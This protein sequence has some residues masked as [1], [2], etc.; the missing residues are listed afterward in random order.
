VVESA[1]QVKPDWLRSFKLHI[2]KEEAA[3]WLQQQTE[4][5]EKVEN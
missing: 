3:L 1:Q 5:I 4:R 2:A